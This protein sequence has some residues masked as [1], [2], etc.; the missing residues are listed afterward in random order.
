M[1]N[2]KQ[3]SIEVI[4]D[5]IKLRLWG[6]INVTD[7]KESTTA[8]VEIA[9]EHGITKFL[10]DIRDLDVSSVTIGLQTEAIGLLWKLR[11]FKKIAILYGDSE[12]GRLVHVTLET[13]PFSSKCR[14]FDNET[15]A[16][17]WLDEE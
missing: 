11:N 17:A 5:R 2:D 3:Y 16:I 14:A 13:V 7:L 6:P 1:A 10:D 15:E 8:I 9:Q 4:A 12:I